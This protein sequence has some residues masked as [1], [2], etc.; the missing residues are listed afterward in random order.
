M[1]EGP[2]LRAHLDRLARVHGVDPSAL[3]R[4]SRPS[5]AD[6]RARCQGRVVARPARR[7]RRRPRRSALRRRHVR[8][9]RIRD[10]RRVRDSSR[11]APRRTRP[12]S[13]ARSITTPRRRGRPSAWQ[14]ATPA[15]ACGRFA[16]PASSTPSRGSSAAISR[17][18]ARPVALPVRRSVRCRGSPAQ[19]VLRA[20]YA[21]PWSNDDEARASTSPTTPA[22]T[23]RTT[24]VTFF[25]ARPP[26]G[27][28]ETMYVSI[29]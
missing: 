9:V 16:R 21:Q 17:I 4:R 11:D 1:T 5:V 15:R 8:S 23:L 18:P 24:T 19:R 28:V 26:V 25:S 13:R 20:S 14:I 2:N 27:V 3:E 7:R 29:L 10:T 6:A 22:V 12:R